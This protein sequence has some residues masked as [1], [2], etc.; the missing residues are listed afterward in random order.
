MAGSSREFFRLSVNLDGF[1]GIG[2][3]LRQVQFQNAILETGLDHLVINRSLQLQGQLEL[4]GHHFAAVIITL[5]LLFLFLHLGMDTEDVAV[6]V[7][8]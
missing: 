4:A 7:D 3:R 1:W 5:F 8:L 6:Q 2:S